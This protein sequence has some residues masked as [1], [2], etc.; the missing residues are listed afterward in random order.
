MNLTKNISAWG[1]AIVAAVDPVGRANRRLVTG[2]SPTG[3][4]SRN[5]GTSARA[6][7]ATSPD[8]PHRNS[9]KIFT[10]GI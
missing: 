10:A 3:F 2:R 5:D 6:R 1:A 9:D 8:V 7:A 4:T